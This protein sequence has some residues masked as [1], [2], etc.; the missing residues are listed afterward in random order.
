MHEEDAGLLWKHV[1]VRT[2]HVEARRSR[3]LVVSFVATVVNFEYAFSWKFSL[4]GSIKMEV[5]GRAVW[6][7]GV[8]S[9]L[10]LLLRVVVSKLRV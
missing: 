2:G 4:D 7:K 10:R 3:R 5:N 6:G 1:Q 8:G 9:G